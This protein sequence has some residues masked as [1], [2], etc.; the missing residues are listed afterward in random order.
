MLP[1]TEITCSPSVEVRQ[2]HV[3]LTY[4]PLLVSIGSPLRT[5]PFTRTSKL[6]E[7]AEVICPNGEAI[8]ADMKTSIPSVTGSSIRMST[9]GMSAVIDDLWSS[10]PHLNVNPASVPGTLNT[11]VWASI[12]TVMSVDD[13]IEPESTLTSIASMPVPDAKNELD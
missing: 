3:N 9:T 7:W 4:S 5:P 11:T 2:V 12:V 10:P 1:S 13:G 6:L 8:I